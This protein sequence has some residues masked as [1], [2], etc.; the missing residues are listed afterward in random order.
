MLVSVLYRKVMIEVM[1][2]IAIYGYLEFISGTGTLYTQLITVVLI[3]PRVYH[4]QME[5]TWL[6]SLITRCQGPSRDMISSDTK[7]KAGI[8]LVSQINV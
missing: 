5:R 3:K 6:Q 8:K 2:E 4:Y 7:P 1:A